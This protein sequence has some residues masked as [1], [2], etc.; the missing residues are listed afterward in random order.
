MKVKSPYRVLQQKGK[1][2]QGKSQSICGREEEPLIAVKVKVLS[3]LPLNS[4]VSCDLVNLTNAL[5]KR[6][7]EN[8]RIALLALIKIAA[9][10][11]L[12]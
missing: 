11:Y 2:K 7:K 9:G 8:I 12:R 10:K 6:V 3:L 4:K 5:F 1:E